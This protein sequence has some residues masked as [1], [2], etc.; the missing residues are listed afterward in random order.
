MPLSHARWHTVCEASHTHRAG[1]GA[2]R[3]GTAQGLETWGPGDGQ[4]EISLRATQCL[5]W[6]Q[7]STG[8]RTGHSRGEAGVAPA[9]GGA[10][11]RV[12]TGQL[13]SKPHNTQNMR[14]SAREH[15]AADLGAMVPLTLRYLGTPE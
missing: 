15:V 3:E 5:A 13:A 7:P 1:S 11:W 12:R 6:A 14:E 10:Q 8:L 4:P 9:R 2:A